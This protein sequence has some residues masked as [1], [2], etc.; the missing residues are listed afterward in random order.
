MQFALQILHWNHLWPPAI[1]NRAANAHS[2]GGKM[3]K[4][5]M[6]GTL[7]TGLS[8]YAGGMI[9]IP[10]LFLTIENQGRVEFLQNA[11]TKTG[12]TQDQNVKYSD[13][14][15]IIIGGDETGSDYTGGFFIYEVQLKSKT[16]KEYKCHQFLSVGNF[17]QHLTRPIVCE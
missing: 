13:F 4:L 15:T 14:R 1:K 12:L 10:V 6:I 17:D 16:G 3:K 8:T 2:I 5:F 9:E 7:I 11:L